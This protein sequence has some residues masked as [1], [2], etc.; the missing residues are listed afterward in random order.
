MYSPIGDQGLTGSARFDSVS[1][2]VQI[3]ATYAHSYPAV[4]GAN[5]FWMVRLTM[6]RP[7]R[8][9]RGYSAGR[10]A[11]A[12]FEASWSKNKTTLDAL[13]VRELDEKKALESILRM[14]SLPK[15]QSCPDQENTANGRAIAINLRSIA[16]A[17]KTAITSEKNQLEAWS[18][19]FDE[20]AAA[21]YATRISVSDK[22]VWLRARLKMMLF[23]RSV[24]DEHVQVRGL[25]IDNTCAARKILSSNWSA[26]K[27]VDILRT[28]T[29]RRE[30]RE[31]HRSLNKDAPVSRSIQRT[32][33]I[34][35]RA[36]LG[37]LHHHY[38]RI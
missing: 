15:M 23:L 12:Q 18:G 28:E 3:G 1:Q 5:R 22:L 10:R 11:V 29:S 13:R 14:A 34:C 33:V 30:A 38:S 19:Q 24:F 8:R 4:D 32:G 2:T 21:P 27:D 25:T 6:S 26:S 7:R 37:G 20:G 31:V 17:L 16:T 9:R 35:S 36:I